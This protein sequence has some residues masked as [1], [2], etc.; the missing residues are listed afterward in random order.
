[1]VLDFAPAL[2][3]IVIAL[4]QGPDAMKVIRELYPGVDREGT[5]CT[6]RN[7]GIAQCIADDVIAQDGAS[8]PG[9]QG[10][11]V[12]GAGEGAAESGHYGIV[13]DVRPRR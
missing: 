2:R 10:K 8:P 1:M 6:Y 4:R 7:N 12:G 11:E 5:A 3:E 9:D 13:M